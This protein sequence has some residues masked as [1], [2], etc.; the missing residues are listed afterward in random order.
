MVSKKEVATRVAPFIPQK[1]N[2]ILVIGECPTAAD[3]AAGKP[4]TSN[5]GVELSR[6]LAGAGL[7]LKE[8]GFAYVWEEKAPFG[9]LSSMM[10]L[11]KKDYDNGKAVCFKHKTYIAPE[12]AERFNEIRSYIRSVNP[13]FLLLLGEAALMGVLGEKGIDDFRGSMEYFEDGDVKIPAMPTHSTS[14]VFKQPQ[15]RFLISSDV[16]RV[17]K[18]L[19]EGWPDPNWNVTINPDVATAVG[20]LE[21]ILLRLESGERVKLGVD[22]ETR[23]RFYIGTVGIAHSTTEGI[24]I[25]FIT[26]DWEPYWKEPTD[27]FRIVSLLKSILEHPNVLVAGQNYHYDAQYLAR[28]WGVRSH[29]Y[30]DTMIAH[31]VVFSA[32]IPKALHVISS[33]YCDYHQYW[34]DESHSEDDDKWEPTWDN[35]DSYQT[36]NVKDCCK[37]LD[38]AEV[39]INDAIVEPEL[40]KAYKFQMDMWPNLLKL[41][42]RGNYYDWDER[43]RQR[44]MLEEQM[45][46]MREWFVKVVPEE[47]YPLRKGVAAW[48]DSPTQLKELFYDVLAQPVVTKR[49]ANK[50]YVPTTEDDALKTIMTREPILKPLCL[51]ILIYRSMGVFYD[52]FLKG[53]PDYDGFMRSMYKLAGTS[54]YRLASAK[55]VFE[56]GLNLQNLPKGNEK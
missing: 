42:L 8:C 48:W 5:S 51:A 54:T 15:L 43:A 16:A 32:D 53:T 9:D 30:C 31:H 50:Q 1:W 47:L 13:K 17:A 35:W 27:E 41:M 38:A 2:G 4:F 3:L 55:D 26:P 36:Y 34:K 46:A 49:N 56:F 39:I 19:N 28:H 12:L 25:P 52:T 20:Y 21:G 14:R 18:H 24:C 45:A 33:I 29:I 11:K 6:Y 22:L 44:K 7:L 37:T 23:R 10:G 40:K